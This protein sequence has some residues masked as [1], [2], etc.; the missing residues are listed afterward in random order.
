MKEKLNEDKDTTSIT[1]TNQTFGGL[2]EIGL[3]ALAAWYAA[4]WW[5]WAWWS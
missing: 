3:V 4:W 2:Q 1:K 5:M